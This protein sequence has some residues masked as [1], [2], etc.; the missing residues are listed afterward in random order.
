MSFYGAS[1]NPVLVC[2]AFQSQSKQPYLHLVE[3]YTMCVL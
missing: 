1:V 3:A 2:F